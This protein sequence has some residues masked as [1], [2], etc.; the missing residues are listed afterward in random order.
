MASTRRLCM[1]TPD[2]KTNF[3]DHL[4]GMVVML[5]S[6]RMP[7]DPL[8][9]EERREIYDKMCAE[10]RSHCGNP[11]WDIETE[12]GLIERMSKKSRAVYI[13]SLAVWFRLV[14]TAPFFSRKAAEGE[15]EEVAEAA[16]IHL[17]RKQVMA[18]LFAEAFTH[19]YLN[20]LAVYG[21]VDVVVMAKFKGFLAKEKSRLVTLT[22][23]DGTETHMPIVARGGAA[24]IEIAGTPTVDLP[25]VMES[26]ADTAESAADTAESAAD[27]AD[28]AVTN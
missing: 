16:K 20:T 10:C 19:Y 5:H 15:S 18:K 27:A 11:N 7:H 25:V 21:K 9:A 4:C 28:V 22:M 14:M 26:A 3:Y 6:C 23:P 12:A 17:I 1:V 8:T 13:Y 2:S 24:S